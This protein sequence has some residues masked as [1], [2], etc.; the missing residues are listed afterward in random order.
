MPVLKSWKYN[1]SRS[2][3]R[4]KVNPAVPQELRVWFYTGPSNAFGHAPPSGGKR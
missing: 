1:A 2:P 3:H 4:F